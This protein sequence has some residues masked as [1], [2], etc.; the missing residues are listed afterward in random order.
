MRHRILIAHRLARGVPA[1]ALVLTL[2]GCAA[3]PPTTPTAP[4]DSATTT[5]EALDYSQQSGDSL[6]PI[7][8]RVME[9]MMV[10]GTVVSVTT[11]EGR[12]QQAFGTRTIGTDDP[13]GVDDHFRVGSITKTMVGTVAL[14][15]A[16][17]SK[18]SLADKVSDHLPDVWGVDGVTV[19]QLLT[20]RS[21]LFSYTE[22]ADFNR[23]LDE[24]PARVWTFPELV[25]LGTSVPPY[26]PP[27][28]DVRYSNTNTVLL[29]M[30]IEEVTGNSLGTELQ[31]RI[32]E[33]LE[34]GETS[35]PTEGDSTLPPPSPHGYLYGTHSSANISAALEWDQVRAAREGT[36]LPTDVTSLDP[37][38]IGAAG[39][40]I[41]TASDLE[42]FAGA[43]VGGTLLDSP[44]LHERQLDIP[45]TSGA[46]MPVL[47]TYGLGLM[48]FGPMYGHDGAIPGFQSFMGHDPDTGITVVVLCTLR[49]GPAGGRPANEIAAG[50]VRALYQD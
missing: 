23:I 21:G 15:L 34:L 18:L 26:F 9:A 7:V 39:A 32:F 36:L 47:G 41:S 10:P 13:V 25:S 11:P 4:A 17:E 43:L 30:V 8:D 37:S 38:W 19:E 3:A 24:N 5:V 45:R 6:R 33:P 49:D 48:A 28:S 50:I 12:W 46:S 22:R 16:E 27:G 1:V 40:A 14:Q 31:N 29:A 2:A 44:D 35:Y 42:T 20:M